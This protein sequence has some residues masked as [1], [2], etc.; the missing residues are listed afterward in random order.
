MSKAYVMLVEVGVEDARR[1]AL[2]IKRAV[3]W[4]G[5]V[6]VGSTPGGLGGFVA[7]DDFKPNGLVRYMWIV[8]TV[9]GAIRVT[10]GAA[11]NASTDLKGY[12]L[13][14]DDVEEFAAL[15]PGETLSLVTI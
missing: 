14:A 12:R 6:S 4:D 10:Q 7:P 3:V 11:P 1:H 15:E 2:P 8:K 13:K 9:D 5:Q